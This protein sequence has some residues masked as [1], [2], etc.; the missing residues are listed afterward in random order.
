MNCF[1]RILPA[2][3]IVLFLACSGD[4]KEITDEERAMQLTSSS[5]SSGVVVSC[6]IGGVCFDKCET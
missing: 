5:S 4:F 1:K 2:S 6:S 3:I